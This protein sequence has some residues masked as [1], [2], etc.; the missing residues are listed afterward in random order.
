[1]T[2]VR[3]A[4]ENDVVMMNSHAEKITHFGTMNCEAQD[5]ATGEWRQLTVYDVAVV[6]NSNFFLLGWSAFRR[7]LKRE[8]NEVLTLTF[9]EDRV[10]LPL[11]ANL[12]VMGRLRGGLPSIKCR[13]VRA[14]A[15]IASV[16][17]HA[18][19]R[20]TCGLCGGKGHSRPA[21][22]SETA[23]GPMTFWRAKQEKDGVVVR[24]P[25]QKGEVE[26]EEPRVEVEEVRSTRSARRRGRKKKLEREQKRVRFADPLEHKPV[27]N[28]RSTKRSS[29][30]SSS[31][32]AL[33]QLG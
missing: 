25:E 28:C 11:G 8:S 7:Q 15:S 27:L 17:V 20:L 10:V 30:S 12:S 24:E 21:C 19:M 9:P 32:R 13:Q 22:P 3:P 26:E 23:A 16:N 31:W 33:I 4:D 5:E 14:R 2:D 6:P 18:L 1:M 29:R